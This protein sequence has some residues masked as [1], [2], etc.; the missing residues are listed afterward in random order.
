MEGSSDAWGEE[1]EEDDVSVFS[2]ALKP[3]EKLEEVMIDVLVTYVMERFKTKCKPY[4][5]DRYISSVNTSNSKLAVISR[6][7]S[8]LVLNRGS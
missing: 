8:Y 3:L 6:A 1:D 4:Q 5:K 7:T 2:A